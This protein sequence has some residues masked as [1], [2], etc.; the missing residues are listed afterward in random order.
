M[1]PNWVKRGNFYENEGRWGSAKVTH[2]R[3]GEGWEEGPTFRHSLGSRRG[4]MKTSFLGTLES[5][6]L[7]FSD[8]LKYSSDTS[9]SL[10]EALSAVIVRSFSSIWSLTSILCRVSAIFFPLWEPASSLNSRTHSWYLKSVDTQW[11]IT[12]KIALW[13]LL[14]Q[15]SK[16]SAIVKHVCA[17]SLINVTARN[18]KIAL[19]ADIDKRYH[20]GKQRK[21]QAQPHKLQIKPLSVL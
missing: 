9:I 16:E 8:M 7:C 11:L 13:F 20:A 4:L 17:N 19:V 14:V 12:L 2:T 10:F 6:E 21:H 15:T 3:L 1:H 5:F 18:L